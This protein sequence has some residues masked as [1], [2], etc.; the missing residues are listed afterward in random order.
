MEEHSQRAK[1]GGS[2][3]R[4]QIL[5]VMA[6]VGL[7]IAMILAAQTPAPP[8]PIPTATVVAAVP[9]PSVAIQSPPTQPLPA[10]NTIDLGD[11]QLLLLSS[12]S[13]LVIWDGVNESQT[14][15]TLANWDVMITTDREHEVLLS[16]NYAWLEAR[17]LTDDQRLWQVPI[18]NQQAQLE[19]TILDVVNDPFMN[20]VWLVEKQATNDPFQPATV[21]L[22]GLDSRSGVELRQ[23]QAPLLRE[24]PKVLPTVN[25]PWL[26][27]DGQLWPFDQDSAGF[28]EPFFS[29]LEFAQVAA[30][31]QRAL[32]L[33]AGMV[34][35]IDLLT[36][37]TLNQTEFSH[38]PRADTIQ[39]M[40]VSPDLNYVVVVVNRSEESAIDLIQHIFAY[41]RAGN[42]LGFWQRQLLYKQTHTTSYDVSQLIRFL[43]DQ[44]L[45]LLD[46]T[47]TLETIDLT[48]NQ[49]QIME[50]A[51]NPE[52]PQPEYS[53]FALIPK[54]TLLP[55]VDTP[56]LETLSVPFP[57]NAPLAPVALANQPLA[58]IQNEEQTLLLESEGQQIVEQQASYYSISRLN[59]PPLL[60]GL[61]DEYLTLFDPTSQTTI[62]LEL[63]PAE[64]KR[65]SDMAG[66]S[67]PD[68]QSIVL[69]YSYYFDE[70]SNSRVNRCLVV[71][72]QTGKRSVFAELPAATYLTPIYWDGQQATIVGSTPNAG[73][74]SYLLWQTAFNDLTQGTNLLDSTE[75][76][77]LWYTVGAPT[78]VYQNSQD[79]LLSYSI[80]RQQAQL[81]MPTSASKALEIEISPDGQT[82]MLFERT[83]PLHYGTLL[84]FDSTTGLELQ[85]QP[86]AR[87]F[88]GQ[89]SGDSQYYLLAQSQTVN[90][91]LLTFSRTSQI[92]HSLVLADW[93]NLTKSDWFGQRVMVV[94]SDDV[95]IL[96][97]IN[98]HWL[99]LIQF[100]GFDATTP[101]RS[102]SVEYVY[103]QP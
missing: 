43:D 15:G 22:R 89:W 80:L 94:M 50:L 83:Y 51:H 45:M 19:T 103:P 55:I 17:S 73:N 52:A 30:D 42:G 99:P 33:G 102:F 4:W 26:L 64:A 16:W 8:T 58:L 101:F 72:L 53:S 67:A 66:V 39:Q 93:F 12:A 28:G 69:C 90:S 79:Q 75:V 76:K 96:E 31:G 44:H 84:M 29:Q 38:L 56:R 95:Y 81:L 1:I 82:I 46:R 10:S 34:S 27:A 20:V 24:Q 57:A 48:T 87:S 65:L 78:V 7:L 98:Q 61:N 92:G 36:R 25:G 68:N 3:R 74:D 32:V 49:T 35:E 77:E 13:K 11:Q 60:I 21:R 9:T 14:R 41:D 62:T 59:A 88:Q 85:R 91:R 23:Y 5:P 97:R 71:D 70:S 18:H 37:Q 54:L 47:G 63:E 2:G 40:L 6:G 86:M 100:N